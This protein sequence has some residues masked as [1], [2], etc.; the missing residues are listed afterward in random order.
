MSKLL[1]SFTYDREKNTISF[2]GDIIVDMS[3]VPQ[4]AKAKIF[5]A[6]SMDCNGIDTDF[7]VTDSFSPFDLQITSLSPTGLIMAIVE[8]CL[9]VEGMIV[10]QNINEAYGYLG[11]NNSL[12]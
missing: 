1:K 5:S 4:M 2:K 9:Q 11:D 8:N 6:V 7:C 3:M 10:S 12:H